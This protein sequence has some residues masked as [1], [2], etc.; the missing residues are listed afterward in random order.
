MVEATLKA[1][2]GAKEKPIFT[3]GSLWIPRRRVKKL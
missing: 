1:V 2:E 3:R